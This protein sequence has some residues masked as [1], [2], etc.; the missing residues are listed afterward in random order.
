MIDGAD[1]IGTNKTLEPP[2]AVPA[3]RVLI[4]DDTADIRVLVRRILE[5]DGRFEVV[6]EACD[7]E[8]AVRAATGSAADV[9][10]LDLSMPELDGLEAMPEIHA[11]APQAKIVVLSGFNA[12]E[13]S[14][15]SMRR[16]AS[17]YVEKANIASQLVP[18]IVG[19][20]PDRGRPR[21]AQHA[22]PPQ[23]SQ[24]ARPAAP[25][26]PAA[27]PVER[28]ADEPGADIVSL[29][30]HE[31]LNPIAILQGFASVLQ[32]G[33][34]SMPQETI[35]ESADAIAR[36]SG[37]LV[38]LIRAF[39]DLRKIEIDSLDLAFELTDVSRL[40]GETVIDVADATRTHPVSTDIPPGTI[41]HVDPLRIRQVVI[42]LLANAKK[43]SP[44]GSP[45]EV[46]VATAGDTVEISVRDHGPGI[47]TEKLSEL[48]GKF[49]RL[50]S[51]IPGTGI[52]L[53]LSRGI[54]RAHGGD[55]VLAE[56]DGPGCRFVL[57]LP[58]PPLTEW[59]SPLGA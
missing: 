26:V 13:M 50:N 51:K 32:D 16:G 12:R 27:A 10:L 4:V 9:V 18:Q 31:L 57:T 38:A 34:D 54:A 45:I 43:F 3:L 7:G 56:S 25:V 46:T 33:L 29:L 14:A 35:R 21:P 11:R 22:I 37:H 28:P 53:Y 40:V 20:F 8:E 24:A 47:P 52:G 39:S 42:N 41:A 44:A 2:R 58:A 36:A 5:R 15:E 55:L 49:A 30:A 1:D 23:A 6:G 17:L 59:A 19:L 48:F